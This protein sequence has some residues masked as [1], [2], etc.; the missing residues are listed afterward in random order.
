MSQIKIHL[1]IRIA[2]FVSV[3]FSHYAPAQAGPGL[4]PEACLNDQG[5]PVTPGPQGW[6]FIVNFNVISAGQV[7]A[8]TVQTPFGSLLYSVT[9]CQAIGP[10]KLVAGAIRLNGEGYLA[11]LFDIEAVTKKKNMAYNNFWMRAHGTPQP[12]PALGAHQN[13]V[14]SHSSVALG[15]PMSPAGIQLSTWLA[16]DWQ[17]STSPF[18]GT[19]K[20][21]PT[22]AA[23]KLH[24]YVN[25]SEQQVFQMPN[26]I[27]FGG[28]AEII[29][30]GRS[31]MQPSMYAVM[32]LDELIV[33]PAG[34]C[35]E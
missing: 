12:A 21:E 9:P 19:V 35:C 5:Q 20:L 28:S 29:W 34:Y 1:S 4:V 3:L 18:T 2:L 23:A 27:P 15:M 31:R 26:A 7:Q 24:H 14:F 22:F 13:P 17:V 11:C 10:V 25:L 8:C 32:Q 30:I 6:A 33:D 16:G